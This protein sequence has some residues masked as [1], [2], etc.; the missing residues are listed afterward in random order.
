MEMGEWRL[1][2][3]LGLEWNGMLRLLYISFG[4]QILP[5]L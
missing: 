3:T 5:C 2:D 4:W 1:T